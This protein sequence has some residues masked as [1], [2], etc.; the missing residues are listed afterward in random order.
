MGVLVGI[1][2][3]IP[4]ILQCVQQMNKTVREV[5]IIQEREVGNGFT[6]SARNLTEMVDEGIE[7]EEGFELRPWNGQEFFEQ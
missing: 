1:L 7:M 3:V 4:C 2:I 6:E 5:F